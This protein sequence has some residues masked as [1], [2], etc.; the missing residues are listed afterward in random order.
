MKIILIND[1]FFVIFLCCIFNHFADGKLPADFDGILEKL[2]ETPECEFLD[3]R[4]EVLF[5]VYR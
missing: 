5:L 1:L 2:F 3:S 4:F